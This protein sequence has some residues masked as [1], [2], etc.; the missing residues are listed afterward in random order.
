MSLNFHSKSHYTMYMRRW[1]CFYVN[2][3]FLW[4]IYYVS[5]RYTL[6]VTKKLRSPTK[7]LLLIIIK[8]IKAFFSWKLWKMLGPTK[9]RF[10]F[11]FFG[12]TVLK[13]ELP[14]YHI[15]IWIR[16]SVVQENLKYKVSTLFFNLYVRRRRFFLILFHRD[17]TTF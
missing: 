10:S 9:L 2:P 1:G 13:E 7:V 8:S 6:E 3:N 11:I 15:C 4:N 14:M 12:Q 16:S 17:R 5:L